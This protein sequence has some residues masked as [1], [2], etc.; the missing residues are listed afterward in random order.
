ML[1]AG[2]RS[3][4]GSYSVDL[5]AAADSSHCHCQLRSQPLAITSPCNVNIVIITTETQRAAATI[6]TVAKDVD[7]VCSVLVSGCWSCVMQPPPGS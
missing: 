6:S 5:R 1:V 4:P 3:G 2:P 7:E